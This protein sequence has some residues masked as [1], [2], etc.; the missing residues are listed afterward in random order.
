MFEE[1][2]CR[3]RRAG[4]TVRGVNGSGRT[5]RGLRCVTKAARKVGATQVNVG[6]FEVGGY[7]RCGVGVVEKEGG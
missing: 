1:C 7:G 6:V 5:A 2:G 4:V 3:L